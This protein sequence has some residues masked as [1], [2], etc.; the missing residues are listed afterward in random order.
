[1]TSLL[2]RL[3]PLGG[4]YARGALYLIFKFF[5]CLFYSLVRRFL[6]KR[7]GSRVFFDHLLCC[8]QLITEK[9][10][11][12]Y[13]TQIVYALD[14]EPAGVLREVVVAGDALGKVEYTPGN[15]LPRV[16]LRF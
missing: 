5:V 9:I 2:S 8:H 1:M 12:L 14:L 15:T 3:R 4:V 11:L 16:G 7:P 13:V 6:R 10:N